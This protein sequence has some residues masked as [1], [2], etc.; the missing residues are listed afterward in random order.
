L[1]RAALPMKICRTPRGCV[2]MKITFVY[3]RFEKFPRGVRPPSLAKFRSALTVVP[4]RKERPCALAD[5]GE[6]NFELRTAN[7]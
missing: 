3:Q 6:R 7:R 1:K 4:F 2:G 5:P